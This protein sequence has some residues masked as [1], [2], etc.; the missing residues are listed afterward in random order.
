MCRVDSNG[1]IRFGSAEWLRLI[2]MSVGIVIAV[3]GLNA[4]VVK[5]MIHDALAT[6]V[7]AHGHLTQEQV[8][9]A[10]TPAERELIVRNTVESVK[11]WVQAEM[12]IHH[13]AAKEDYRALVIEP[14]CK[15]INGLEDRVL[16]LERECGSK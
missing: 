7:A 5:T 9:G 13:G 12:Q 1:R 11:E 3:S 4:F 2:G 8:R 15:Q 10:L 14:I 6:H 16:L